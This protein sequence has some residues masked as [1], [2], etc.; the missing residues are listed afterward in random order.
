MLAEGS[1]HG[2]SLYGLALAPPYTA[3]RDRATRSTAGQP[4]RERD[5]G[6]R[7]R[8]KVDG[9]PHRDDNRRDRLRRRMHPAERAEVVER[10][11]ADDAELNQPT[12]NIRT[13]DQQRQRKPPPQRRYERTTRRTH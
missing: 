2:M 9:E 1:S 4:L 8:Q 10:D 13:D 5:D 3:T 11:A 12:R 7:H 6:R